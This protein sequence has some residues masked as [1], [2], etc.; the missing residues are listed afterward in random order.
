MNSWFYTLSTIA[1]T[2]A[3]LIALAATF[4]VFRLNFISEAIQ[5]EYEKVRPLLMEMSPDYEQMVESMNTYQVASF[6]S[7]MLKTFGSTSPMLGVDDARLSRLIDILNRVEVTWRRDLS[8][9]ERVHS[10]LVHEETNLRRLVE[11]RN[12]VLNVL[13]TSLCSV[14]VPIA[15]SLLLLPHYGTMFVINNSGWILTALT[16]LSTLSIAY[17]AYG[18]WKVARVKSSRKSFH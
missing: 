14:A 3:A 12:D 1:Q 17:T 10:F 9:N 13:V 15:L 7:S 6:I 11:R 4:I 5:H 16:W 18:I 8:G 2:L